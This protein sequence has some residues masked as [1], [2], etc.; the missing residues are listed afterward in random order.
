MRGHTNFSSSSWSAAKTLSSL[1]QRLCIGNPNQLC[2]YGHSNTF[3][4]LKVSREFSNS[5]FKA[6]ILVCNWLWYFTHHPSFIWEITTIAFLIFEQVLLW[7]T[8][9]HLDTFEVKVRQLTQIIWVCETS[10][11]PPEIIPHEHYRVLY[12]DKVLMKRRNLYVR[13]CVSGVLRALMILN[14]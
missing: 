10:L 11:S 6:G 12:F 1:L 5:F 8:S 2:V 3:P 13:A 7:L 14:E 4:E 9:S